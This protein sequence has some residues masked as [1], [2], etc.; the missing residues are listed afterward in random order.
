M[1][2]SPWMR[3]SGGGRAT[4]TVRVSTGTIIGLAGVLLAV[5][6]LQNAFVAGQ[7]ILGWA[8]ACTATAAFLAPLVSWLGRYI[9]RIARIA[10]AVAS[11]SSPSSS[12]SIR[13][14]PTARA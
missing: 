11:T 12:P 13:L 1:P 10:A 2:S 5:L 3:T 8:A 7:R 6:V 4:R 14:S 9:P